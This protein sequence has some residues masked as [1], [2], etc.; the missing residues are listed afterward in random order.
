MQRAPGKT[1][2]ILVR[3]LKHLMETTG[4]SKQQLAKLSGVSPRMIAYLLQQERVP[5]VDLLE[6]LASVFNLRAWIL[7]VEN[8]P[9]CIEACRQL[10]QLTLN[11]L[12]LSEQSRARVL[13]IT[14]EKA[15]YETSG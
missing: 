15:R 7:L 12:L 2:E 5:T 6:K 9:D 4:T 14:D 11:Y 13:K 10:E 3:N 1:N 8:L